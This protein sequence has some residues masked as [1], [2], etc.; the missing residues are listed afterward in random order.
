[1]PKR[2]VKSRDKTVTKMTKDGA[3][4]RNMSTGDVKR[5][6]NRD[7]S[8]DLRGNTASDKHSLSKKRDLG[9]AQKRKILPLF[10]EENN[11]GADVP[12]AHFPKAEE[13]SAPSWAEGQW[14]RK[15]AVVY[16]FEDL[17]KAKNPDWLRQQIAEEK[18][19][20]NP[21]DDVPKIRKSKLRF[22][23]SESE[24]LSDYGVSSK[25]RKK[26]PAESTPSENISAD[27]AA[28]QAD[29]PAVKPKTGKPKVSKLEHLERRAQATSNKLETARANLPAKRRPRIQRSFNEA[30][31]K[32]ESRLTLS[33]KVQS[34][35]AHIK[36]ALPLRPVKFGANIA[37]AGAHRKMFQVED[38]NVGIKAAHRTELAAEG[39]VRSALRH[40]KTA[41]YKKVAKLEQKLSDR[42]AKL[43]YNRAVEA[44]PQLKKNLVARLW[45]KHKIKRRHMKTLR[46]SRQAAIKAKKAATL[47]GK[48]TKAIAMFIKKNPK[49]IIIGVL[50]L[51]VINIV[52][53]LLGILQGF[54]GGGLGAILSATYLSEENDMTAASFVYTQW[55]MDLRTEIENA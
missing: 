47:T 9:K 14:D 32:S 23:R 25:A 37:I 40:H 39:V 54:G 3:V 27:T 52:S 24:P 18:T 17:Q 49:V 29:S 53:S 4:E 6:S 22:A 55:E 34:Q 42:S 51:L 36:G 10:P 28:V 26:I 35:K 7:T 30:T 33:K 19:P 2:F 8:F 45:Q 16:Q 31:G 38:E 15:N 44:N 20:D 11:S 1:M 41:P 50:L 13:P 46:Q 48:A 12:N 21:L 5:I 43:A